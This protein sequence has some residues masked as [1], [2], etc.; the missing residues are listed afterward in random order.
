MLHSTNCLSLRS[1]IS[2]FL[3][4]LL[5]V[6]ITSLEKVILLYIHTGQVSKKY[7]LLAKEWKYNC[8][9]DVVDNWNFGNKINR[10]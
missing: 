4:P 3:T 6:T 2:P 8:K 7:D 10:F 5:Y 9:Q 1:Y